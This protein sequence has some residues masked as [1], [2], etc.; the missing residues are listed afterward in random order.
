MDPTKS[1]TTPQD[2]IDAIR[3]RLADI[4][5][6]R[7]YV[8][9]SHAILAAAA[10]ALLAQYEAVYGSITFDFR[11]LP[12]RHKHFVWLVVIGCAQTPTGAHHLQDFIA[13]GGTLAE[14]DAASTLAM[15]AHGSRLLDSVAASWERVASDFSGERAYAQAIDRMIVDAAL[16]IA[17]VE[18]ALAAGHACLRNF[19]RVEQHIIRAKAAG[20]SD[21]ALAEALTVCILPSGNPGFVQACGVWRTLILAGRV[22]VSDAFRVATEIV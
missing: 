16:D 3:R 9:P 2:D 13:A 20:A 22:P 14:I 18:M 19:A 4:R 10:P 1:R 11:A 5:Q 8:L 12:P 6:H 17:L 21:D 15:L 7:G